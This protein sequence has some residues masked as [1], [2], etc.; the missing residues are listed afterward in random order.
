MERNKDSLLY[1]NDTTTNFVLYNYAVIEK[2]IKNDA[3]LQSVNQRK[4]AMRITLNVL[5]GDE[6]LFNFDT[7]DEDQNIEKWKEC[8]SGALQKL[9]KIIFVQGKMI[10]LVTSSVKRENFKHSANFLSVIY[11]SI[12]ITFFKTYLLF[13]SNSF[14]CF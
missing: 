8:L 13:A 14:A 11:F 4:L 7:C 10:F 6:P 1:R 3:F 2:L 12:R 9:S 5:T